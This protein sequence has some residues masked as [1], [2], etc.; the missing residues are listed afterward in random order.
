MECRCKTVC[1]R[2]VLDLAR[3]NFNRI[4]DVCEDV[5]NLFGSH[6][7]I[8]VLAESLRQV[9]TI[10]YSICRHLLILQHILTDTFALPCEILEVIASKCMPMT[11]VYLQAYN[12]MVWI[13]EKP[14]TAS[15]AISSL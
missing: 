14:A 3:V 12:V 1:L 10:R 8:S 7:G 9:A 13:C 2:F 6:Y 15:T 11:V 4:S 5:G